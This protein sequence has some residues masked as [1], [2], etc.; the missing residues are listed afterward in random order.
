MSL[1]LSPRLSSNSHTLSFFFF[2]SHCQGGSVTKFPGLRSLKSGNLSPSSMPCPYDEV[3]CEHQGNQNHTLIHF[4][5]C[6]KTPLNG[7]NG[8]DR[9][10]GWYPVI[11][12]LWLAWHFWQCH[13]HSVKSLKPASA[14]ITP[15][16][17]YS[18]LPSHPL[19]HFIV[20]DFST[21]Q[22]GVTCSNIEPWYSAALAGRGNNI[23]SI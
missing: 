13:L 22:S 19:V 8:W 7:L 10:V 12:L 11:L 15:F 4:T 9:W 16:Q 1:S 3:I 5:T 6:K 14:P 2:L 21:R 17:S 23:F 18:S 20:F